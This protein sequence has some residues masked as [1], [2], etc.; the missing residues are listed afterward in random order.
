[1][2]LIIDNPPSVAVS[3]GSDFLNSVNTVSSIDQHHDIGG[4]I[5]IGGE[6][7]D[8]DITLESSQIDWDIGEI[9]EPDPDNG[10]GPYEM[11]NVGDVMEDSS[12]KDNE[13]AVNAPSEIC[14]D[15]DVENPELDVMKDVDA[16]NV[17]GEP[18]SSDSSSLSQIQEVTGDRSPL[19][20]TEYRNRIL[21]DL[22]E[23]HVSSTDYFS[24]LC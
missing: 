5:D 3:L 9:E 10:L 12:T 24:L 11:V 21:D 15:V 16:S 18:K 20:E 4:V 22:F 2:R 13:N 8:W 14:W 17:A 1:M 7:I 6:G 19:L 23:V